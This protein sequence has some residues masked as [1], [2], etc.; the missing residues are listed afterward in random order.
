MMR[1]DLTADLFA[2]VELLLIEARDGAGC[3]IDYVLPSS[4]MVVGDAKAELKASA[5][6][7]DG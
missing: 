7:L 5:T 6:A 4:L 1:Q 2:S 3:C